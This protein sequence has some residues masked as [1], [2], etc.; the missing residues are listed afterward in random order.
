[1]WEF[2]KNIDGAAQGQ[3]FSYAVHLS[4]KSNSTHFVILC[5][6]T[7]FYI[8][9]GRQE[10]II[11]VKKGLWIKAGSKSA[12]LEVLQFRNRSLILLNDLCAELK[13][14]PTG[15]LG[16]GAFG[17]CFAVE[18]EQ[19]VKCALKIVLDKPSINSLV[20]SEFS[21]IR[22]LRG[23]NHVIN[24]KEDSLRSAYLGNDLLGMGYLMEQIG[25][26]LKPLSCSSDGLLEKLFISLN[27]I[28]ENGYFH[29]DARIYNA[30]LVDDEVMWV[31]FV[32]VVVDYM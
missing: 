23:N 25:T 1:V 16:S 17:R 9:E 32:L 2:K 13:V 31:D 29:G 21:K 11:S 30:V 10:R 28:H 20:D 26:P 3:A 5:D 18:D 24:V 14:N 6:T 7:T 22:E 27:T 4:R 8:I 19:Q 15:Y 12:L